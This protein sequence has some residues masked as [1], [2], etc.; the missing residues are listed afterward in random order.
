[1]KAI[2]FTLLFVVSF[3][4]LKT[5]AQCSFDPTITP[6]QPILCP[7]SID[8]LW[9][10]VYDS[11]QWYADNILIPGATNQFY[12]ATQ[13]DLL[14]SIAVAAT[15]SSCTEFSPSVLV[16]GYVFLFPYVIQ[17]GDLGYFDPFTQ[18]TI[19][20]AGDTMILELGLPYEV[21]VQWYN[22]NIPISGA[23]NTIYLAGATGSYTVCG[24]PSVCPDYM[25]CL[26][27]TIDIQVNNP[28]PVI[29]QMNDTLV[30]S[31]A[32]SYQWYLNGN[33]IP[34]AI[35]QTYVPDVSGV[36][37][38]QITDDFSCPGLSEPFN[39]VAT[40][41]A[42]GSINS[43]NIG[44]QLFPT[45]ANDVLH[46]IFEDNFTGEISIHNINGQAIFRELMDHSAGL[47]IPVLKF[48][49][50]VYVL[51][52]KNEKGSAKVKWIKE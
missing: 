48:L 44:F 10:Q 3:S 17:S 38:V 8:T 6:S 9:T 45:P 22:N 14:K 11:Y 51:Q 27:V 32:A 47:D 35:S 50:G 21:N 40:S 15:L 52:M 31:A 4:I 34:G 33:V 23:T 7:N 29:T 39:Y 41:V 1:M 18:T 24:A 25:Q 2:L 43:Q 49:P 42:F 20:C 12:V 19:L 5:R 30:S 46:L 37:T 36:Y 16:D 26:G 13:N 28:I